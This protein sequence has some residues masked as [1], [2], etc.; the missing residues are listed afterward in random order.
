MSVDENN[1]IRLATT[2]LELANTAVHFDNKQNLIG[3]CDYYDKCI[4]HIDEVLSLLQVGS[5]EWNE[6]A[7]LRSKYDDRMETLR[8]LEKGKFDMSLSL[9]SANAG[10]NADKKHQVKSAKRQRQS[11]ILFE[12][13][14]FLNAITDTKEYIA[15]PIE[16][17][18]RPYWQMRVLYNSIKEGAYLTPSIYIPTAIWTQVGVKFSGLHAKTTAYKSLVHLMGTLASLP[19][20]DTEHALMNALLSLKTVSEEIIL[21]QNYLSKS[22]NFIR[23]V[24][25]E[26]DEKDKESSSKSQVGRLTNMMSLIGK[27]VKKYAEVGISRFSA[28]P[29]HV[30][31]EEFAQYSQLTASVCQNCQILDSWHEKLQTIRLN[32]EVD[33]AALREAI[34]A[35]RRNSASARSCLPEQ[36]AGSSSS[37]GVLLGTDDETH[38]DISEIISSKQSLIQDIGIELNFISDFMKNVVCEILLRDVEALLERYLKKTRK[39]FSRMHW[40]DDSNNQL[41]ADSILD[42]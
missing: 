6:F 14:S 3:A 19:F 9:S 39:G 40:D 33:A 17:T 37:D 28:M 35:N 30:T 21:L 5:I 11:M 25:I 13:V 36:E 1:V 20:D 12:E 42:V 8:D 29:A 22:F 27:S 10:G 15:P 41:T 34:T 26:V 16:S 38:D 7:S 18:K 31:D 24:V 32:E 4:L 23:E 2:A